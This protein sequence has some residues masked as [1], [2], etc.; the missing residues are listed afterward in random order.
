M[1]WILPDVVLLQPVDL[2]LILLLLLEVVSLQ[3]VKL[4]HQLL[5]LL[6]K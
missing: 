5:P 1:V 3:L 6:S 2:A 4:C